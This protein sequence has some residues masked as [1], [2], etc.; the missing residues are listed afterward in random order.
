MKHKILAEN[1]ANG[2][3]GHGLKRDVLE[4]IF[5]GHDDLLDD[6]CYTIKKL[7]ETS[8]SEFISTQSLSIT[9]PNFTDFTIWHHIDETWS[10]EWGFDRKDAGCYVYGLYPNGAPVGSADFLDQGVIYIGESRATTRNCMLGRRTDFKGTV[11]NERLS[12]YGCGT[13]FKNN[14]GKN[15]IDQTYQAYLPMHSSLVKNTEMELLCQYYQKYNRIPVCNPE[16][17]LRRVQLKL[18]IA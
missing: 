13:A 5:Q 3:G 6:F 12:P 16:S 9:K 15:Q 18:G 8:G 4:R 11:R 10:A 17:D 7:V 2:S 1:I 14:F